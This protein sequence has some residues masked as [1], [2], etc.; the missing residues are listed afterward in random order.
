MLEVDD[1]AVPVTEM[2]VVDE[3]VAVEMVEEV[4]EEVAAKTVAVVVG[5][6]ME[7]PPLRPLRDPPDVDVGDDEPT[8]SSAMPR[9]NNN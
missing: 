4:V 2:G 8:V 1:D 9:C 5:T 6:T 7:T 3:V